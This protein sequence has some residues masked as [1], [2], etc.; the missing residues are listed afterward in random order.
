MQWYEVVY[1]SVIPLVVL[2]ENRFARID[3]SEDRYD[4]WLNN[5][6]FGCLNELIRFTVPVL[7]SALLTSAHA[8][9]VSDRWPPIIGAVA[10]FLL[11]DFGFY[12]LHRINHRVRL[13]WQFHRTHHSDLNLD[14]STTF[15][16]HPG[17]FVLNLAIVALATA[18]LGLTV[19]QILPTLVVMRFVELFAHSNLR[20]N[21]QLDAWLATVIVTPRVHQI[22]H[23]DFQ[24]ETDSNYGQA[25]TWWDRWFGTFTS[26]HIQPQP[27]RFGLADC[28]SADDQ[29][30]LSLLVQPF[31]RASISRTVADE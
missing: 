2:A 14:A 25:L 19:A 17:E 6:G 4:R 11:M 7:L 21:P 1:L 24:P 8:E 23:S 18:G 22:H 9:T 16:H 27:R 31:Q 20:I 30:W 26:P 10:A 13:L 5:V 29:R 15:R 12:W 28:R 3:L